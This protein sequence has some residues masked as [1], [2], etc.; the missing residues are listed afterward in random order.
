M[1]RSK[2]GVNCQTS[3]FVGAR[4]RST[5]PSAPT[6]ASRR[7]GEVLARQH[8]RDRDQHAG[9]QAR[10][11][12]PKDPPDQRALQA[13]VGARIALADHANRDRGAERDRDPGGERHP[14][15]HGPAL[16][17]QHRF[18]TARSRQQARQRG[19]GAEFYQQWEV[20]IEHALP[21]A[22]IIKGSNVPLVDSMSDLQA[23]YF[24]KV[25]EAG[26]SQRIR[27]FS[28]LRF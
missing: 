1:F 24:A 2:N 19:D 6:A 5:P 22:I 20:A 21:E 7:H 4:S 17:H 12:P 14:L 13:Q 27:A 11:I 8:R 28:D 9:R 3:S 26:L 15:V 10:D 18:E 16:T 23:P 25:A